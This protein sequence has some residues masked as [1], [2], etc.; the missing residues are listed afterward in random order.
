MT[1]RHEK[2]DDSTAECGDISPQYAWIRGASDRGL[3]ET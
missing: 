3:S 1:N 2:A